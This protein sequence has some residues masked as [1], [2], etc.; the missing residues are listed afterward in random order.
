MPIH[1]V[2]HAESVT[3]ATGEDVVDAELSALGREQAA[4]LGGEYDVALVS[5]LRRTKQ[6]WELSGMSAREVREC[7]DCRECVIDDCDRMEHEPLFVES[8]EVVAARVQR[9]LSI[10]REAARDHPRVVV[11]THSELMSELLGIGA[12]EIE[13]ASVHEF[14]PS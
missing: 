3:N 1:L 6:T 10:L 8:E 14:S 12:D 2:R 4:R 5:P 7:I 9:L 11:V 13:N